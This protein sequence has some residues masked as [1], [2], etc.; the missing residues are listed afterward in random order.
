MF[1]L[2]AERDVGKA[3]IEMHVFL[4]AD[5]VHLGSWILKKINFVVL[6]ALTILLSAAVLRGDDA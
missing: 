6:A 5:D 4:Y 3:I 2:V 1:P